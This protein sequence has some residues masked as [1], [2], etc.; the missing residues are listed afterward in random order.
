MMRSAFDDDWETN[1]DDDVS[2][3]SITLGNDMTR[4]VLNTCKF[5]EVQWNKFSSKLFKLTAENA[6]AYMSRVANVKVAKG[7]RPWDKVLPSDVDWKV[8]RHHFGFTLE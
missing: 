4:F 2:L 5:E 8:M 1:V 3:S 6:M 7:L